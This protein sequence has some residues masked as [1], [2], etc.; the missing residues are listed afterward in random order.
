[1]KTN[2]KKQQKVFLRALT[3][4]ELSPAVS[5]QSPRLMLMSS[6]AT[7]PQSQKLLQVLTKAT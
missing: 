6:R 2:S 5:S 4:E 7:E 3:G 1:M